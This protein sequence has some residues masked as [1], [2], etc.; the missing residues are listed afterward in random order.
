MLVENRDR[1]QKFEILTVS[2]QAS[3][4]PI[5]HMSVYSATKSFLTSMMTALKIEWK[6]KNIV[7]TTT[8]PSGIATTKEMKDSIKSM[9]IGGKLT[10]VS[11]KKV[12]EISLKALRKRKAIV[13]P[14][15]VN[16]LVYGLSKIF[17]PYFLAKKTGKI[18]A[19]SQQ[20]RGF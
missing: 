8:C 11:A 2:S 17:T 20:K 5:P 4:Q 6:D 1:N 18:W 15:M 3:F 12:A 13:I 9:G 10:T 14:G 16:R 19:K 7:V